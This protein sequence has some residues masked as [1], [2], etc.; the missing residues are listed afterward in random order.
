MY[1][2][3]LVAAIK[4]G[5]HGDLSEAWQI[6]AMVYGDATEYSGLRSTHVPSQ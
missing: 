1:L 6:K 5:E 2:H 3:A 4:D